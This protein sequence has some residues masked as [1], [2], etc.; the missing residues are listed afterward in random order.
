M[1]ER[2]TARGLRQQYSQPLVRGDIVRFCD[3]VSYLPVPDSHLYG[4]LWTV[5]KTPR[6]DSLSA[7]IVQG[8]RKITVS[9]SLLAKV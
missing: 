2:P 6:C 3:D 4:G 1:T 5:E 8:D 7:R 9:R